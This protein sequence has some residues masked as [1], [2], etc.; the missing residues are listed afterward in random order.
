VESADGTPISYVRQGKGPALI[1]VDGALCSRELGPMPKLM[2]HLSRALTVFHYDRR[3]R[4]AS[5]DRPPYALEREVEDI[6]AVIEVAGGSAC[7]YGASSGGALA[8]EAARRCNAV[9]RIAVYE[10]PFIVDAT[11]APRPADFVSQI[12]AALAE[13]RRG[14][15]VKMFMR[16]V[17]T[18]A[19]VVALMRFMPAWPKLKAVAH[20]LPYDMAVMGAHQNGVA[21]KPDEW[22]D[23][24]TPASL[25]AGGKSP[26][27]IRN[28]MRS[29]AKLLPEGHYSELEGQTH[30][31]K[32]RALAP[33]LVE[34]FR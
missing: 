12:S 13:D 23:I 29:L 10:A 34:F 7:L 30:L 31:V 19:A 28:A 8:L 33:R 9:T 18:P 16:L 22:S 24:T 14:D 11:R 32:P 2:P 1:L 6:E 17:G 5:G 4:G 25:I 21:L 3:G 15:V 26:A 20:T 27:W